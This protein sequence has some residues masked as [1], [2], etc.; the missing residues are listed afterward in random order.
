MFVSKSGSQE[1]R[2]LWAWNAFCKLTD[3][4]K[5]SSSGAKAHS[6]AI[7]NVG[8]KAPTPLKTPDKTA[9]SRPARKGVFYLFSQSLLLD[10]SDRRSITC[11][12]HYLVT[13]RA[14]CTRL[15]AKIA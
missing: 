4:K 2:A 12:S 8:A 7:L 15:F 1:R 14:Q 9:S 3:R 10:T 13:T 6:F 11:S 5:N